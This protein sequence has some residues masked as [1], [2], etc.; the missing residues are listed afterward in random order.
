MPAQLPVLK[1]SARLRYF[2]FFYL[3]AMQ[4]I[5]AGFALTAI[6]NFL[7]GKGVNALT[8]GSFDAVIGIPWVFQFIWGALID[9]YQF[10]LMGHRKHWIVFSQFAALLVTL[11]LLLV[12]NPVKEL[13][14]IMV[15]FFIHSIFASIQDASVDATAIA[16][17]PV[18]E[19]GRINAFMR[20]GL[21]LG[22]AVG[23][24][25]FST[26][27]HYYGFF[28]AAAVQS[29]LLLLFTVLTYITKI[30]RSDSYRPSFN[31]KTNENPLQQK[32]E[33]PDLKWLFKQL[34]KGIVLKNSLKVFGLIA[35]V[36][37]CLSIFIRSFSFHLIHNLHWD[38]NQLS[39]LQGTWGSAVTIAVTL[40]GGILADRIGPGKLQLLV[41]IAI[42][43]FFLV[44]DSLGFLWFHRSVSTGGVLLYSLADPI[45]SVAAMP[46]LM[47]LCLAKVEGSQFTTYMAIVNLC[48]VIG[49]YVSGWGMSVTTAPVI[50]FICGASLLVALVLS[51]ASFNTSFKATKLVSE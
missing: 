25:G 1:E 51:R 29:L 42:C 39:V 50:G 16:I 33:N 18:D 31:L 35:L 12:K 38:D 5:P 14:Y 6:A 7:I 13:N 4:G 48:D 23:A 37:L 27:L 36:Y 49:A 32:T 24:A 28:Y 19:Q 44:F 9:R 22:V 34:Y 21:L 26:L 47:A 2:T 40:G 20:S 45:F 3:Y 11:S 46:V 15:A 43:A 8:I 41:V 10:S 17:V 30:D